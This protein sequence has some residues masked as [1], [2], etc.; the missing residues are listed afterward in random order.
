[1]AQRWARRAAPRIGFRIGAQLGGV[2]YRR[3]RH[4]PLV[5][6]LLA[7]VAAR[8]EVDVGAMLHC[9]RGEGNVPRARQTG[10]YLI[11][12]LLGRPYD[13]VGAVFGRHRSTVA[14]AC[15]IIEDLRDAPE[16]EAEIAWIEERY[17]LWSARSRMEHSHAA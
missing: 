9:S 13:L 16:F 11:N 4:D 2:R 7:F 8:F 1:M 3:L 15:V 10:M 6:G 5:F 14:H 17:R 12:T